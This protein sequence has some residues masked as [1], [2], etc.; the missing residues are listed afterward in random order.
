MY[1]LIKNGFQGSKMK[2]IT[3]VH[4]S[5]ITE[6]SKL[7]NTKF[8]KNSGLFCTEGYKLTNEAITCGLKPVFCFIT[9]KS[10]ISKFPKEI[11]D[12][13]IYSVTEQIMK[14]IT[15]MSTPPEI[16][17][18]FKENKNEEINYDNFILALDCVQDP[19]NLGAI[20]R[21]A[22]AFGIKNIILGEG[23]CDAYSHKTLRGAMG[24]VFRLNLLNTK[25]EDFLPK[26][27]NSDY[28]I[29]G[30][31]LDRDFKTVDTLSDYSKKVVVIGNEGNGISEKIKDLCD[32]GMFIPMT[33]QNESLNAAVAASILMWENQRQNNGRI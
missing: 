17:T 11:D 23:C 5:T 16:I 30:T 12:N 15:V 22:E 31:G 3:S 33:G 7:K 28:H 26:L 20:L 27:K 6:I 25:L 19:S 10:T 13:I 2:K 4:N 24:S 32:F 29:I 9:E 18:V 21:S 1:V 14:K 8:R